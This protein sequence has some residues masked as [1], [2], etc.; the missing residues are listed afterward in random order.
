MK[1]EHFGIAL[2]ELMSFGI[3]MNAWNE[4]GPKFD[5]IQENSKGFLVNS[6]EE[7]VESL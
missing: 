3:I 2:I 7:F 6:E 4:A 1:A 5:I